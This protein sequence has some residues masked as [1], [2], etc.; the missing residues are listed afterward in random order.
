[1][2]ALAAL[3]GSVRRVND[4]DL[5]TELVDIVVGTGLVDRAGINLLVWGDS[6]V[7]ALGVGRKSEVAGAL[8]CRQVPDA[9]EGAVRQL[10]EA[11]QPDMAVLGVDI[12][13]ST[14][15][16][17]LLEASGVPFVVLY[18]REEGSLGLSIPQQ[19]DPLVWYRAFLQHLNEVNPAVVPAAPPRMARVAG[20]ETVGELDLSERI[21][22]LEAELAK[23][24]GELEEA[25]ESLARATEDAEVTHRAVLWAQ[26]DD[27]VGAV[28]ML[29]EELGF[30]V[31]E[32]D[33]DG[34][35]QLCLRL[36][37]RPDWS[38]MVEIADFDD[39][40]DLAGLRE[41]NRHRLAFVAENGRAPSQAWWIVNDHH[42]HD[43]SARPAV[44]A[45]PAQ[46][47]LFDLAVCSTRDLYL[48]WRDVQLGR[49]DLA[50]AT[51]VLADSQPGVFLYTPA[52]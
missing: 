8:V 3:G 5:A 20:W 42:R 1:V 16:T 22:T 7:D 13:E 39:A 21:D 18:E 4:D 41:L 32:L 17:V 27:L 11:V 6:A 14:P 28:R 12:P 37:D 44:L 9:F 25:W 26:G 38:G 51:K 48:L 24:M 45:D 31:T 47:E 19:A 43:P 30:G 15:A 49:I 34:R 35:E 29:L 23:L 10:V 50:D 40:V 33:R 46:A 36:A 52:G 2:S